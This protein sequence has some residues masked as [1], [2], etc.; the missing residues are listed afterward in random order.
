MSLIDAAF[1]PISMLLWIYRSQNTPQSR[2]IRDHMIRLLNSECH[3]QEAFAM[4]CRL[5]C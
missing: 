2:P 5:Y 4:S 1:L 3:T